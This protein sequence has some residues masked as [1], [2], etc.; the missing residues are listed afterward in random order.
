MA[1]DITHGCPASD[2]KPELIYPAEVSAPPPTTHADPSVS[3]ILPIR[4]E[5]AYIED[6]LH[7]LLTQERLPARYDIIV[8][9]G[10]SDD[11]TREIV[12][13]IADR[14]PRVQ[15]VDNEKRIVSSALNIG[16]ARAQ[17]EII[18]RV[19]GHTRVAPDFI[20]ANLELLEEHPEAWSV[21][22]PIAHRGK[23]TFARGVAAAMSS[24]FGVGGANHRRETYEGYAEGAVFP[25]FRRTIFDRVGLFDEEL[26]RNQDDEFNFRITAG[27]GKIYI[28]PRVKHDY[29]VRGSLRGLAQQY[30]QY[31]YWKVA[32]F[33]KHRKIVAARHLAP[34]VFL[35]GAPACL[36]TAA[37]APPPLSWVALAPLVAYGGLLTAAMVSAGIRERSVLVGVSAGVA[38]AAMHVA[39]G[40]GTLLGILAGPAR[41]PFVRA[42]MAKI[43]R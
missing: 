30:V 4:N 32:V 5:R 40:T 2:S 31:S 22:G 16:I 33:R 37:I 25:A 43:T 29:F 13:R 9:D 26:V 27:G 21:G 36:I 8:V 17:G 24:R 41:S 35:V 3:V 34:V 28:S 38:T 15:L 12:Q 18:I 39:Y 19:D 20:R 6:A 10:M 11:G 23:T 14:D 7:A 1:K 42:V